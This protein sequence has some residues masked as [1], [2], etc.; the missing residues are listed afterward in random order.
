[1][2]ALDEGVC[3]CICVCGTAR[4]ISVFRHLNLEIGVTAACPI[5]QHTALPLCLCVLLPMAN[6]QASRLAIRVIGI[7]LSLRFGHGEFAVA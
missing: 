1:M 4:K 3:V 7:G 2:I 5:Q 6:R